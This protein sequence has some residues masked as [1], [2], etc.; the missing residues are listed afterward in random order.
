[1]A[2]SIMACLVARADDYRLMPLPVLGANSEDDLVLGLPKLQDPTVCQTYLK[3]LR[4]FAQRN[5]PMSCERPIA[6]EMKARIRR[7][8]M[9]DLDPHRYAK[10]F[11]ALT[12]DFHYGKIPIYVPR[13]AP[14]EEQIKK[15]FSWVYEPTVEPTGPNEFG[16]HA[17][18]EKTLFF[19]RA[20]LELQGYPKH[21]GVVN[22]PAKPAPEAINIVQFG[23]NILDPEY[24]GPTK[25]QPVRGAE[26]TDYFGDVHFYVVSADLE[27]LYGPLGTLGQGISGEYLLFIDGR[28]YVEH[29]DSTAY[30]SLTQ[31]NLDSPVFLEPVCLYEFTKSKPRRK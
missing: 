19:R 25:C 27:D 8:E 10:L 11:N 24:S 26:G 30:I 15:M 12:K 1:M 5:T 14:V 21:Y 3:N 2:L 16:L 4:Y 9:E 20:K 23:Y 7:V 18:Q 6:P 17:W 31:I 28:P 22:E 13:D 29:M